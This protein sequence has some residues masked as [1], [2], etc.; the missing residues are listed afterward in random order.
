MDFKRRRPVLLLNPD[1]PHSSAAAWQELLSWRICCILGIVTW[2][3]L[4]PFLESNIRTTSV[5]L[6]LL[7]SL[8]TTLQDSRSICHLSS[9][10]SAG[11][12][13]F[14]LYILQRPFVLTSSS[15]CSASLVWSSNVHSTQLFCSPSSRFRGHSTAHLQL[16]PCFLL[17]KIMKLDTWRNLVQAGSFP[18]HN[19]NMRKARRQGGKHRTA[20]TKASTCNRKCLKKHRSAAFPDTNTNS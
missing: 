8:A 17:W 14:L 4:R 11:S 6:C 2:E 3:T 16:P 7:A 19:C 10:G 20:G 1:I 5:F 13:C 9:R 18:S 15:F 12:L